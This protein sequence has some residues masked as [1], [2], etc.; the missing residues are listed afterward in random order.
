MRGYFFYKVVLGAV[1]EEEGFGLV[2]HLALMNILYV[3]TVVVSVGVTMTKPI[4]IQLKPNHTLSLQTT[5]LNGN[6]R[7]RIRSYR[8]WVIV[9]IAHGHF[10]C[11]CVE[12]MRELGVCISFYG[13]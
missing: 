6:C 4:P 8:N 11:T 9:S 7:P 13:Q 5:A 3:W 1:K 2:V 10:R 12:R